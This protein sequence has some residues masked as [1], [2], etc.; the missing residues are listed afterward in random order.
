MWWSGHVLQFRLVHATWEYHSFIILARACR[1]VQVRTF[2][3]VLFNSIQS[4]H[5]ASLPM[6]IPLLS[7]YR[8]PYS[9]TFTPGAERQILELLDRASLVVKR[10]KLS[11]SP[12]FEPREIHQTVY[13]HH[14]ARAV[15]PCFAQ[16]V[17]AQRYNMGNESFRNIA[18]G[19]NNG[20]GV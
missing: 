16:V 19:L 5:A 6:T 7:L 4:F 12:A 20:S 2:Q 8:R 13:S 15:I 9:H 14:D 18:D 11:E 17:E 1:F 10:P 3:T